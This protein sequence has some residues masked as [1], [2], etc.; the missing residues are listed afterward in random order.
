[1]KTR[2]RVKLSNSM[3]PRAHLVNDE[4]NSH[5]LAFLVLP[6]PCHPSPI[7][8]PASR[9]CWP[10]WQPLHVSHRTSVYLA[11]RVCPGFISLPMTSTNA[12]CLALFNLCQRLYRTSPIV[13]SLLVL[14]FSR[15][16][17]PPSTANIVSND[18]LIP[19]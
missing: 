4:V 8:L 13:I 3:R 14:P 15:H 17:I 1:M 18:G 5:K 9:L 7:V 11:H 2:N 16:Y 10:A 19:Y 12:R 6:T